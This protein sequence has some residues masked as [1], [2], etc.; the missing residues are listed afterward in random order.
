[1][2]EVVPAGAVSNLFAPI[3]APRIKSIS[4]KDVRAFLLARRE[5]ENA[6]DAQPALSAVPYRSCFDAEDL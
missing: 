1:M 3:Q 2:G 4:R 5:Y 6:I